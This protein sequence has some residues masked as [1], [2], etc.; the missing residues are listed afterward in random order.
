MLDANQQR[1]GT[2]SLGLYVNLVWFGCFVS[3]GQGWFAF[4]RVS[5]GM[6]QLMATFHF[7]SFLSFGFY[8]FT[9]A[10]V[11]FFFSFLFLLSFFTSTVSP[12]LLF[13][14]SLFLL[15]YFVSTVSLIALSFL[16]LFSLFSD[17][18]SRNG[19]T[20][21]CIFL[22]VYP[23]LPFAVLLAGSGGDV[24]SSNFCWTGRLIATWTD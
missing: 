18:F 8:C 17:N 23:M 4:V 12:V 11:C 5:A 2:Q 6:R 13:V 7:S 3:Q 22:F 1:L 19:L 9:S 24:F 16:F 20:S 21:L 10:F 15:S 14:F